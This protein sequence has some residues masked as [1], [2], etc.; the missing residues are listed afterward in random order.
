M[1]NREI[2]T[3]AI[4]GAFA[5]WVAASPKIRPSF[6]GIGKQLF[7]WKLALP[8]VS[9]VA[10]V[11]AA[12]SMASGLGIW[13]FDFVGATVLW[14]LFTGFS[15]FLNSAS[16]GKD[17]DFFKRRFL[18]TLGFA[19]F[20]EFFVNVHVFP[21]LVELVGQAF[22]LFVVLLNAVASREDRYRPIAKL[23]SMILIAT[24]VVLIGYTVHDL[25][26][27]WSTLDL[28][29]ML[30]E[31][32]LP[33]WLAAIAIPFLYAFA[34]LMGYESLFS[35]LRA[36]ASRDP[37]IPTLRGK[38]G[39]MLGLRGALVDVDSFRGQPAW[40]AARS[41]SVREAKRQVKVFKEERAADEAARAAA[42]AH[43]EMNA[44]RPG[45]GADG[46]VLDRREFA[47]TKEA[48]QYIANCHMGWYRQE[49]R[50]NTYR[51]D[52][53]DMLLAVNDDLSFTG[54]DQVKTKVRKDGQAW[55][56]FRRT[57]SGHHFGIGAHGPPPSQWFYN[58]DSAPD[59]FPN[60]NRHGW[61]D[62]MSETPREWRD[63][64][65]T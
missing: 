2:A 26:S 37:K 65:D 36:G 27:G 3:F 6:R 40:A 1:N 62:F 10:L 18:E 14:F 23:T 33:I 41:T 61:T 58:G 5:V 63:E 32:L 25:V 44:G 45:V 39:M 49:G 8:L 64:P 57:P 7:A 22:L 20:L 46:L 28:K 24:T 51:A 31:L 17:P 16:A 56:A 47:Q 52:L 21:L 11:V 43:L 12:V 34:F 19:A 13:S 9:Y 42:R 35:R 54:E 48:L 38:V 30:R 4:L 55:Y 15:W 60:P 29:M 53:L 59:G 50:P